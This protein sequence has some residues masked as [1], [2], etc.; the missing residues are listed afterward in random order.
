MQFSRNDTKDADTNIVCRASTMSSSR[1][2]RTRGG[3]RCQN[4]SSSVPRL[5]HSTCSPAL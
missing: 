3:R 4:E 5:V 2:A 1:S